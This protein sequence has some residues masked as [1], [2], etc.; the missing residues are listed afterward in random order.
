[1]DSEYRPQTVDP[2]FLPDEP[3]QHDS[4]SESS[5]PPRPNGPFTD[6]PAKNNTHSSKLRDKVKGF[7][8]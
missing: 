3:I 6:A 8:I 7:E 4:L 5:S 1:M 2:N